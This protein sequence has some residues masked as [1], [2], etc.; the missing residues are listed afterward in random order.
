MTEEKTPHYIIEL[1]TDLL[2]HIDK[3]I[4]D[5]VNKLA[6]TTANQ[7]GAMYTKLNETTERLDG[8]DGR[9]EGMDSR[10]D[11]LEST[12]SEMKE[13]MGKIEAHIGRYEVRA[14]NIEQ[15]LLQ[16]HKIRIVDLEKKVFA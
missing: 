1:K 10:F 2:K 6:T 7:Y 12:M 15:I 9:F 14:T 13:S 5:E 8:M 3:K 11:R 16:D 4:E